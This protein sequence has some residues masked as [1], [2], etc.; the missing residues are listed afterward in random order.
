MTFEEPT[1]IITLAGVAVIVGGAVII[2]G[3]NILQWALS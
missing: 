3:L 2:A 1:K